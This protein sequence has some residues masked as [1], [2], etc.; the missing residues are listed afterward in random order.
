M[1][2]DPITQVLDTAEETIGT[3]EQDFDTLMQPVRTSV[4][5]RFPIVFIL[6]VTFGVVATFFGF[7][8]I[9]AEITW[10]SD[11]PWLVLATGI[12]V[13]MGTGTL[14]KKLG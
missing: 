2:T 8:R 14:Y 12:L 5:K 11:R 7:E 9:I 13:L 3:I 1:I 4:F 10:L 6:L